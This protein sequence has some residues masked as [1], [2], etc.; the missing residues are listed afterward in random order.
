[1]PR[2]EISKANSRRVRTIKIAGPR[3]GVGRSSTNEVILSDRA[4]SRRHCV[5]E[6]TDGAA[7]I[8]DT[9]S[10]HGVRVNGQPCT[11]SEIHPGDVIKLGPYRIA[12]LEDETP[13]AD[14]PA[15][16]PDDIASLREEIARLRT[17]IAERPAA[18]DTFDPEQLNRAES[19]LA[20]ARSEL[21]DAVAR[22]EAAEDASRAARQLAEE[23]DARIK[24]LDAPALTSNGHTTDDPVLRQRIDSL[25]SEL[26]RLR[27]ALP[28]RVERDSSHPAAIP[29]EDAPLPV[30]QIFLHHEDEPGSARLRNDRR[31]W[32]FITIMAVASLITIIILWFG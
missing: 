18:V 22:A 23:L 8:L 31:N 2:I 10:R 20:A 24:R 26:A 15:P 11:D 16:S 14:Q 13:A 12:L 32:I 4:I 25:E 9:G 7:R 5:I 6:V 21:S 30:E 29:A 28:A 19:D 3:V 27:E 17:A 1:M